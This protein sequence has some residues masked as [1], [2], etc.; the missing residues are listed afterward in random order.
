[1]ETSCASVLHAASF[2]LWRE[3]FDAISVLLSRIDR[4]DVATTHKD[5]TQ[6][7]REPVPPADLHKLASDKSAA[8]RAR[9]PP[10]DA[11]KQPANN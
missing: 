9:L 8:A 2:H 3:T 10:R 5:R 4:Q 11:R 1:M 6:A 7:R